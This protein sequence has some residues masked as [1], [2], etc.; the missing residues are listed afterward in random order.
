MLG[1]L[2]V[3]RST[4][5]GRQHRNEMVEHRGGE[6][7]R[8]GPNLDERAGKDR[9]RTDALHGACAHRRVERFEHARLRRVVTL[10]RHPEERADHFVDLVTRAKRVVEGGEDALLYHVASWSVTGARRNKAR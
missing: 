9:N 3:V 7:P 6:A 5:E 8:I 4:V 1:Q 2:R 10:V